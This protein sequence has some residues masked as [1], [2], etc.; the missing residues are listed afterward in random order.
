[1]SPLQHEKMR[2]LLR[3]VVHFGP[4][5]QVAVSWNAVWKLGVIEQDADA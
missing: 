4:D 3:E 5:G 1:M 2:M